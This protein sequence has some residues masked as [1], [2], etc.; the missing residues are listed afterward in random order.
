[1]SPDS[2]VQPL[3]PQITDE[4]VIRITFDEE[5]LQGGSIDMNLRKA[6]CRFELKRYGSQSCNRFAL[7]VFIAVWMAFWGSGRGSAQIATGSLSGIVQDSTGAVIPGAVVNLKDEA[8]HTVQITKSNS[9]GSFT[10]SV[11]PAGTYTVTISHAGFATYKLSGITLNEGEIRSISQIHPRPGAATT[12]VEVSGNEALVPIDSGQLQT[13]LNEHMVT[14]L[15]IEGRDAAEL[16]KVMPGMAMNT[17]LGQTEYSS[18]VTGTTT[19]PVGSFSASGTAP[20]GGLNMTL[21]GANITDT[22]TQG[23]QMININQDQTAQVSIL[24]S[25]FGAQYAKGPVLFQALSKSGGSSYH[26]NVYLYARDQVLNADDAYLKASGISRPNESYFYPGFT[27]G[28]PIVIPHMRFNHNRDKL[29]FFTGYEYMKQQPP[30]TLHELFVPT[31]EMLAGNFTPAYLAT[32]GQTGSSGVVPCATTIGTYCATSGI[33]NGQIPQSQIDPNALAYAKLFP[34]PNQDPSTHSGFNYAYLDN[35]PLNHWEAR[36]KINYNPKPSTQIAFSYTRQDEVSIN[37][38]GIY[39]EPGDTLPYPTKLDADRTAS[40]W[41]ANY[42]Q[43]I[44]SS[45]TNNFIFTYLYQNFPLKPSDSKAIDPATIGFTATGPFKNPGIPQVPNIFSYSCY[46]SATSGCFPGIYG[47]GF[48]PGFQN[49]A[50]GYTKHAPAISDNLIKVVGR[51]TLMAGMY[52]DSNDQIVAQ[53]GAYQANGQGNYDFEVYGSNSTGNPV[54]DFVLGHASNYVQADAEPVQNINFHQYSFYGQDRWKISPRLTA[55]YGV[56]FDH[57]GQWYPENSL[58]F[59]VWDPALYSNSASAPAFTGLTWHANDPK[60]PLSGWESQSFRPLPRVGIAY[61]LSGNGTTVLRGGYGLYLWQVSYNDVQASFNPPIGVKTVS[62]PALNSFADAANYQP[63]AAIG[64]N[65]SINVLDMGD[66]RTPSTSSW[67]VTVSQRLP[68]HSTF[69]LSYSGN[70]TEDALL[71]DT[72]TSSVASLTNINKIPLGALF[73]P[74]PVTGVTYAPG[75]VSSSALLDYR[76]YRNYQILS[77]TT[78]GSYSNYNALIATWQKQTG[79]ITFNV[80]YTWSKAMG[81]RDGQTD[82]ATY[83]NG[84]T[85]D[86]FVLKNN[87]APL[88]FDRTNIFNAAYVINLPSPIHHNRLA[89]GAVNGWELS[90]ITQVQS[91][92]PLQPNTGG[93]FN[94]TFAPGVSNESLLGT[95]SQVLVPALVCNPGQKKYFNPAC[96]ATPTFE[97]NGQPVYP[98]MRGPAYFDSDLGLYKQ[99]HAWRESHVQLRFTAFNFLNHPLPQFGNGND[100][101]LVLTSPQG[102]NTNGSTNGTPR[103]KVGRR[104]VEMAIKYVF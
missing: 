36:A 47:P 7:I 65:G 37:N 22:G 74:D 101:D 91:G 70:K 18:L 88:G 26:G 49:G 95:D 59:A 32:L 50:F 4:Q 82:N 53:P 56:R 40:F 86:A 103:Y 62:T 23:L 43:T 41:T 100:V 16:I 72:S 90:G 11:V 8:T 29:F 12:T 21:D 104:V 61:D 6:S 33:V 25:A 38:F 9:T 5:A 80:N 17:G 60:I 77:V 94:A 96:F 78:H 67:N 64:Q 19:G 30:G 48:V 63:S 71:T 15:S 81:I 31:P 93:T 66:D 54:A 73:G 2:K 99:F 20:D 44:G 51:H 98:Y 68:G 85:T 42:T 45:F 28:G 10:F 14:Q 97:H 102:M 84:A 13:T 27:L 83:G 92:P 3:N 89:E 76:P 46:Q 69:E 24:N 79:P 35:P 1:M 34:A 75:Q 57:E 58:G 52:W 87:Y 55:T 39:Y